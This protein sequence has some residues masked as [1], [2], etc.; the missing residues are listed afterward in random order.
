[1]KIK[2]IKTETDYQAAMKEIE[3]LF[4]A[5]PDTPAGDRLE[6]LTTL[7]EAYEEQHYRIPLPDPNCLSF[8]AGS[9]VLGRKNLSLDDDVA[10]VDGF[11]GRVDGGRQDLAGWGAIISSGPGH[12]ATARGCLYKSLM[13]RN[14][15]QQ[16][17]QR[18]RPGTWPKGGDSGPFPRRAMHHHALGVVAR[19]GF[20]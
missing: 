3:R 17:L 4:A 16:F 8:R 12:P 15:H 18:R 14:F 7:V 10:A 6:V 11:S 5:V 19:Y 13:V 9:V 2:P 1:M 20:G